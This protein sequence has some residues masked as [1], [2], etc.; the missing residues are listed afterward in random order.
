MAMHRLYQ[1]QL[2]WT[3]VGAKAE[4][5]LEDLSFLVVAA[6]PTGAGREVKVPAVFGQHSTRTT[7][8]AEETYTPSTW[9][10]SGAHRSQLRD[11]SSGVQMTLFS[12]VFR[13]SRVVDLVI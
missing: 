3:G 7:E 5:T 10:I 11:G 9:C 13:P 1:C 8:I 6:V 4:F 12:P 2:S